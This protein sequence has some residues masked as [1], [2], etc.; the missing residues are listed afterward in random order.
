MSPPTPKDDNVHEPL[1]DAS[2][3]DNWDDAWVSCSTQ[4][5][6]LQVAARRARDPDLTDFE[7]DLLESIA[8]AKLGLY[9]HAHFPPTTHERSGVDDVEG[10]HVAHSPNAA[11]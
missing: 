2:S 1:N 8:P 4:E 7:N 3:V 10:H 9:A 5:L 6:R 11:T